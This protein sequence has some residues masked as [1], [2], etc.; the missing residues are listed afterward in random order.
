[1]VAGA[2][3]YATGYLYSLYTAA[4]HSILA[5]QQQGPACPWRLAAA[6]DKQIERLSVVLQALSRCRWFTS[7]LGLSDMPL[8]T[9]TAYLPPQGTRFWRFS[10]RRPEVVLQ[11]PFVKRVTNEAE[12]TDESGRINTRAIV[13]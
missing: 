13:Y 10:V 7:C 12:L 8:S 1:M 3:R 6:A 2:V 4:E 11:A 5:L 9:P